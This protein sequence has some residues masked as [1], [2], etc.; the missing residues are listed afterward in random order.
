MS[1]RDKVAVSAIVL[2]LVAG[3]SPAGSVP[4]SAAS[5]T[6]LLSADTAGLPAVTVTASHT[7]PGLADTLTPSLTKAILPTDT[8]Q[9][10]FTPRPEGS[11]S[12]RRPTPTRGLPSTATFSPREEC[13]PPTHARV[14]IQF[15]QEV[16]DYE[17]QILE[18]MRANG[19]SAGLEAGIEKL[20]VKDVKVV[21]PGTGATA[22]AFYANL[23]AVVDGDLTGDLTKET[24]VTI[25]QAISGTAG[26]YGGLMFEMAVFVIGCRDGQ[27]QMLAKWGGHGTS[28]VSAQLV[29]ASGI[30]SYRDLNAD[31]IRE[32]VLAQGHIASQQGDTGMYYTVLEWNGNFFRDL[33]DSEASGYSFLY[34]V[35]GE[36]EFADVDGNGTIELLA[37]FYTLVKDCTSGR[38]RIER[39]IY[40]WDGQYYRSMWR[41]PGVPEYRFQAALDG[42]YYS[43]IGLF[44]RAEMPYLRAV[45]DESLKPGSTAD[46]KKDAGCLLGPDEKPD[47]TEPPRIKAYARFR[48]VELYVHIGRVMEAESHRTYLR[49]NYPLG[50]P[51]YIYAYLANTFWWEYVKDEDITAACAAVRLEAER[52]QADVFGLFENYGTLNPGPTLD[53]ICPFSS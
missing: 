5:S 23:S 28:D 15:A 4:D 10:S 25:F 50:A 9:P 44:D 40:M 30:M 26:G 20:G 24:T 7:L 53:T 16:A 19:D 38:K 21:D 13:P 29:D 45:F 11:T 34:I 12:T 51:G 31:G 43:G 2:G 39:Y 36:L 8:A 46:W 32:I 35:N 1:Y 27:Y 47:P 37:P 6:S 48:L 42:D 17:T 49:T 33:I 14:E 41:D 52:F 18:F 3:C 22:P